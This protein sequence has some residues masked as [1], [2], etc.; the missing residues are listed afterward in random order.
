MTNQ[1]RAQKMYDDADEITERG[2]RRGYWK[3]GEL[4]QIR[5]LQD[6]ALSYLHVA[7]AENLPEAEDYQ[8]ARCAEL[9]R[10]EQTYPHLN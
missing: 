2:L 4:Q 8:S 5:D 10:V 9:D 6:L 7:Q 1:Q 3:P